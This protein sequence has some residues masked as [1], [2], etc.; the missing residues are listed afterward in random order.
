MS[1]KLMSELGSAR[2]NYGQTCNS[3]CFIV[4]ELVGR[5]KEEIRQIAGDMTSQIMQNIQSGTIVRPGIDDPNWFERH[6][7]K[8]LELRYRHLEEFE[9]N[10]RIARGNCSTPEPAKI[11]LQTIRE[12]L[13]QK[14][15]EIGV[16]DMCEQEIRQAITTGVFI[17][18]GYKYV[19]NSAQRQF[20]KIQLTTEERQIIFAVIERELRRLGY[21]LLTE[22]E[23]EDVLIKGHFIRDSHQWIYNIAQHTIVKTI[24][25]EDFESTY[26]E[27]NEMYQKVQDTLRRIGYPSMSA[28]ECNA[29]IDSGR[30]ER[31]GIIR[32]Y[33]P[34][35][36]EFELKLLDLNEYRHRKQVL[37]HQLIQLGHGEISDHVYGKLIYQG[38][39]YYGGYRYEY[40]TQSGRYERIEL[41]AEE[42]RERVRQLREQLAI[43]GYGTMTD[44]ECNV[45]IVTGKFRYNGYEWVYNS[46]TRDYQKGNPYTGNC[47]NT[48]DRG[49]QRPP[50][51]PEVP[52]PDEIVVK[53]PVPTYP[54]VPIYPQP[55][56]T[57]S[58]RVPCQYPNNYP[59]YQRPPCY[60]PVPDPGK[61]VVEPTLPTNVGPTVT[62]TPRP[63]QY[64]QICS[65]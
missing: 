34:T 42:Y 54:P 5:T 15:R 49:D 25:V 14:L 57:T 33:N 30:F 58:P 11:Q 10:L 31:G 6:A 21:R 3:G 47:N 65:C 4:P 17:R 64:P 35:N 7:Q 52:G 22:K 55:T 12:I 8:M 9:R 62:S 45:A 48:G 51:Q 38:Y 26:Q 29:T 13:E 59:C 44:A 23:N 56:T 27:Y 28:S 24:Y 1:E 53:P 37:R 32:I 46:V 36:R 2:P 41:T 18:G 40:N 19:Y 43:I 63:C 16:V 50:C 39:F 20:E 61:L 60:T